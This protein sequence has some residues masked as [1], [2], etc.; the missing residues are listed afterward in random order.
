MF[1]KG[2]GYSYPDTWCARFMRWGETAN[3]S[4]LASHAFDAFVTV[5][6]NVQFQQSL[7]LL[8][9]SVC[10]LVAADNRFETLAPYANTVLH[11]LKEPHGKELV[12]I[13][14]DGQLDRHQ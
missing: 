4:R 14:E 8:P 13:H 7:K 2:R 9:L 6:Q 12:L 11:W 1:R 3:C 10:I 5:D